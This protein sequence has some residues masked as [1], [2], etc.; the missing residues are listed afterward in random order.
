MSTQA[1]TSYKVTRDDGHSYITSMAAGVTLEQAR[2]Y[3]LGSTQVDE[4]L[5][6]GREHRA[7]VIQVE[8][9]PRDNFPGIGA[10][11]LVARFMPTAERIAVKRNTRGE[12]GAHFIQL[13]EE[14]AARLRT[15]PTTYDTQAQN[16]P[17]AYLH[18]F[19]GGCDWFITELDKGASTDT[20][21]EFQ[22]Q[23]FGVANIGFGGGK[24][25]ICLPEL[26]Q[27]ACDLDLYW[28]PKPL[29]QIETAH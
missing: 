18:Y 15:M 14:L 9:A 22:W 5:T 27:N 25:Y 19:K 4:D 24:G 28:T 2:D 20:P 11:E 26:L 21:E 16:D 1:L 13:I 8:P 7:R 12:E 29:S 3:F 10:W 6:T 23:M 17:V